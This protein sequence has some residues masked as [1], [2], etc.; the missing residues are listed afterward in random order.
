MTSVPD[1]DAIAVRLCDALDPV[2][3]SHGFAAGQSGASASV[4][5]VVHCS[6]HRDFR[7]RFPTLA[8]GIQYADDGACTDLNI[9]VALD[10]PAR[11]EEIHLD[12]HRLDELARDLGRDD[13]RRR[14]GRLRDLPLSEGI[15]D[16][17]D[18]LTVI[19]STAAHASNHD[20]RDRHA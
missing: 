10:G 14:I 18:V 7:R 1:P 11:L 12:G 19:F 13:L 20:H 4:V 5:G 6:D 9:S 17:R 8:P 16:L 3:T 15:T 2:M